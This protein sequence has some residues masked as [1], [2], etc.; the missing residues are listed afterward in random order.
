MRSWHTSLTVCLGCI[1]R[2]ERERRKYLDDETHRKRV[3]DLAAEIHCGPSLA[4]DLLTLAG[5]DASIVRDAS[6]MCGKVESMKAYIIDR[7]FRKNQ[8]S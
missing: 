2:G 4:H 3:N 5:D 6:L 7:R 1:G 8:L